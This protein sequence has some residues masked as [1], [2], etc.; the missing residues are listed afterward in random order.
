MLAYEQKLLDGLFESGDEVNLSDL[1]DEFA[2]RMTKV[3]EALMDDA[4]RR[5]W[6]VGNWPAR[7]ILFAMPAPVGWPP[8]RTRLPAMT[9]HAPPA[10]PWAVAAPAANGSAG[11]PP[12]LN[13]VVSTHRVSH[14]PLHFLSAAALAFSVLIRTLVHVVQLHYILLMR[15]EPNPA[16][17]KGHSEFR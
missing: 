5:G 10:N 9:A 3:R 6:F 14:V 15:G 16:S 4:I 11:V 1:H 8:G 7:R 12:T 2:E 13:P 17:L